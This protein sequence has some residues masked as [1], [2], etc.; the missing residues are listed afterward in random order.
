MK[1]SKTI[2]LLILISLCLYFSFG[3]YHITKFETADEHFW[4][5][6]PTDGRIH[7]YWNAL[8][9]KDW[10]ATRINDKPGIMLAYIS[11]I[12]IF[13]EDELHKRIVEPA[14]YESI[15]SSAETE[16]INLAFRL[17]LLI[18]NGIFS[19]FFFWAIKRLT[20]NKWLAITMVILILLNPIIIG[21]SQII[22]P[23]SLLWIFSFASLISLLNYLEYEK[24]Q[25][26]G[27]CALF[28]GFSLL[29][30]YAAVIFIPFFF[31]IISIRLLQE[32]EQ[33][34]FSK[35]AK[36]FAL[37]YIFILMGAFA[38]FALLMPA[39]LA[40]IS[41][42]YYGTIGFKGMSPIFWLTMFLNLLLLADS[43]YTKSKYAFTLFEK[44]KFFFPHIFKTLFFIVASMFCL[45]I[46]NWSIGN[47]FLNI[48]GIN[49][50][51]G[52]TYPFRRQDFIDKIFLEIYPLVFSLTPLTLL[53]I[54][55]LWI[56]GIFKPLKYSSIIFILSS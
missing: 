44:I 46:V 37:N 56:K 12:G 7:D 26:A 23:D 35:K 50:D 6:D 21:V 20:R 43:Y 25:D 48:K 5:Y 10:L 18:F 33:I 36:L 47:N 45:V 14:D 30:K 13:F 28:L 55:A 39:V 2:I 32:K 34:E 41:Y 9:K 31:A 16:K 22:N 53:S 40:S 51:A 38:V 11:G 19:L 42:F 1:S 27:L 54:I 24:K 17:P 4:M 8:S 52:R 3:F 29:S 15:F 49:F